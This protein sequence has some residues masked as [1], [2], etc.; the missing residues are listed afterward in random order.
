MTEV[1]ARAEHIF[2]FHDP[3]NWPVPAG[4]ESFEQQLLSM[5]LERSSTL[6]GALQQQ[7]RCLTVER[8]IMTRR[9]FHLL[10]GTDPSC[11][12]WPSHLEQH[13]P[14]P[15]FYVGADRSFGFSILHMGEGLMERLE[16][17]ILGDVDY[18]RITLDVAIADRR[19]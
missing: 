2:W 8:R 19:H 4:Q 11:E 9:G 7:A 14:G 12:K 1:S 6:S 15:E 10:L 3:P 18:P 13:I 5:I 17:V 16:G